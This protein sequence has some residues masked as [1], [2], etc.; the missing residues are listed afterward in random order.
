MDGT[1]DDQAPRSGLSLLLNSANQYSAG[2]RAQQCRQTWPRHSSCYEQIKGCSNA[3]L[4]PKARNHRMANFV[5]QASAAS[6]ASEHYDGRDYITELSELPSSRAPS[7]MSKN[8]IQDGEDDRET[9]IKR[10]DST[11]KFSE[12]SKNGETIVRVV[13]Q[14]PTV[15]NNRDKRRRLQGWHLV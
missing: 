1:R 13:S 6:S 2:L 5:A 7:Y 8:S 10:R 12:A 3:T 11:R 14:T 15:K 9:L 4:I